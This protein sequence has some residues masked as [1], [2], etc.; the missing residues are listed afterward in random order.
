MLSKS[1]KGVLLLLGCLTNI[2]DLGW[3]KRRFAIIHQFRKCNT[4]AKLDFAY[5]NNNM[6]DNATGKN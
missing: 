6:T 2:C 5:T 1:C 4:E 3:K